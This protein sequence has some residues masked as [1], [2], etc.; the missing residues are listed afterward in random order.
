MEEILLSKQQ[1]QAVIKRLDEITGNI[2]TLK[3]R[4]RIE[5]GYID[6]VDMLRLFQISGRTAQRWRSSGR[7][8]YTRFGKKLYYK[9]DII[10]ERIKIKPEVSFKGEHPPPLTPGAEDIDEEITC[11]RCPLF[12][13]LNL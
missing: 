12:E 10:L 3:Q 6:N 11:K 4:S 7:L 13:L 9:A 2:I 8:P 5:D 1:Y